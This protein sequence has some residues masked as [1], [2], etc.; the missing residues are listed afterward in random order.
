MEQ[1]A[2]IFN[3]KKLNK[4]ILVYRDYDDEDLDNI[5]HRLLNEDL[6]AEIKFSFKTK[7]AAIKYLETCTEESIE[8]LVSG[9]VPGF[10]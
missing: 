4:Q 9:V 2:R 3:S 6:I 1:H 10:E 8:K 7:E 5:V